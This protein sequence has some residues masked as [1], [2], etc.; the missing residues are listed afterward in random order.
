[1]RVLNSLPGQKFKLPSPSFNIDELILENWHIHSCA[2]GCA[3]KKMTLKNIIKIAQKKHLTAI[4]ITDHDHTHK[5]SLAVNIN[6]LKAERNKY[7]VSTFVFLGAEISSVPITPFASAQ[8][9]I[10]SAEYKLFTANHYQMPGWKHPEV[11]SI[12]SYAEHLVLMAKEV[13]LS[14]TA[15]SLAHPLSARYLGN[16]LSVQR[17]ITQAISDQMLFD[18]MRIAAEHN[19]GWELYLNLVYDDPEFLFRQWH[20]GKMLNI[21]FLFGSDA[22]RLD[23]IYSLDKIKDLKSLLK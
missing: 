11:K 5:E 17:K 20:I 16:E 8:E 6:K 18:T 10:Q 2:S 23:E 7:D 22:H 13:I 19:V 4:A 12:E 15:N 21:C 14:G 3:D 9:V 1:M